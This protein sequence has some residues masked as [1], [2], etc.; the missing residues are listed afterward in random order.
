[1]GVSEY[2]LVFLLG[3]FSCAFIFYGFVGDFEAPVS[4]FGDRYSGVGEG[5]VAPSDLVEEKDIVVFDDMLVLK[6]GG[7]SL[8]SYRDTG[9][10]SPVFDKGANGIRVVPKGE[11]DISVGDIVS[12]RRDGI[13][14]VHRVIDKGVDEDGT[15][16]VMKGDNNPV[17]DGKVRFDDIAYLTIG[18]IY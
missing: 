15:Y 3:F 5:A 9:S 11:D 17:V 14:I 4:V 18:V 6:V 8:S 16:F 13:L 7:I 10:M 12:Y 1:M 2:V